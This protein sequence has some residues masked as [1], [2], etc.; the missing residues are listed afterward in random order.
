MNIFFLDRDIEK[1]VQYHND[2]HVVKMILEYVQLLSSVHHVTGTAD[3]ICYKLTHQ[4]HPCAVWARS[5]TENYFYLYSLA[6]ALGEEYT[7]RYGKKHRSI[8][9]MEDMPS[10]TGVKEGPF[11]D[12]PVCTHEDFKHMEV[13]SA[14]RAYYIR[15]K[16]DFCVWTGRSVPE[17]FI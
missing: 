10:P 2:K 13:V 12:P 1:C 16:R 17:W 7:Y 8:Y 14:Y 11:T 6:Y 5:S 9:M 15:D 3:H 4:N